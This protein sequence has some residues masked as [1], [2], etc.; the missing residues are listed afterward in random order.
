MIVL[1]L[2]DELT[3][4]TTNEHSEQLMIVLSVNTYLLRLYV[5][6]NAKRLSFIKLLAHKIIRYVLEQR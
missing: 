3:A 6:N 2:I 1:F 5:F 4:L